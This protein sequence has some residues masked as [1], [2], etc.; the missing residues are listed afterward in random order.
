MGKWAVWI[1]VMG[2]LACG[3]SPSVKS[4]G[5]FEATSLQYQESQNKELPVAQRIA[6]LKGILE[7]KKQGD[8]IGP[9]AIY[10]LCRNYYG[11]KQYDSVIHYGKLLITGPETQENLVNLGKY[12]HLQGHY[13]EKI[14]TKF[15]S[16]FYYNDLAKRS[17]MQCGD[18]TRAF[19]RIVR[20]GYLQRFQ[21]D[22]FGAKET[23]TSA[24]SLKK[25]KGRDNTSA[26][27]LN[28]L[29]IVHMELEN[30]PEA[31]KFYSRAIT[32]TNS[33]R[34]RLVYQNNYGVA[35]MEA[36]DDEE[37]KAV[38]DQMLEDAT[39]HQDSAEWARTLQNRGYAK[40]KLG[41]TGALQ[42]FRK[43]QAISASINDLNGLIF[44]HKRYGEYYS[45]L[46]P[47]R[48]IQ[49]FDTSIVL[50]RE[51]GRPRLEVDALEFLVKIVPK[52][53]GYKD[54]FIQLTDSLYQ[55]EL[56][57]KTQFAY[58]KYQNQQE[59]E[60]LLE[61]EAATARQEAELAR[62]ETQ[63]ILFISFGGLVLAG[64]FLLF[65][66]VKQQH[67][68][69]KREVVYNTEKRI[70]QELHD[71]LANDVFGL[72][73]QIQG[74]K[75]SNKELLN[76]LESI[77]QTSRRISH[78]NAPVKTGAQFKEE[79]NTLIDT[80]QDASTTILVKGMTTIDWS[81]LNHHKCI[82]IHR[83]I[84]ELLVNM[85]KHAGASLVLLQFEMQHRK[86]IIRYKDNGI[87]LDHHRPQGIGLRS[88][89]SRI[90]A[91]G[92]TTIFEEEQEQGTQI[93]FK[94]PI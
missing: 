2:C 62:Q 25:N 36:N 51:F 49:H 73:T 34:S 55:Q 50:A 59:K 26:N 3:P 67:K 42:D 5:S 45:D 86:F 53:M 77:Y 11:Q 16:A 43:A 85:K 13:H 58:L 80:Y 83:A 14:T 32:T 39:V 44:S 18:S 70:S 56:Q 17:F 92:G 4:I 33:P 75:K 65:F 24:L 47:S 84:H 22:Y 8:T 46:S 66:L 60:Q 20:L 21:G 35:L 19:G 41:E 68:K 10:T 72:M 23:L 28:E 29:G 38:F 71:G 12:Y 91:V 69:E 78:E 90:K 81:L 37:A 31:Q 15:D 76:R 52:N 79:L 30:I 27:L 9:Y 88:T 74:K 57:V 48:A 87:G 63:K 7:T 40:W 61:L 1:I 54:R 82:A 93:T 94:I 64:S 89:E 6:L